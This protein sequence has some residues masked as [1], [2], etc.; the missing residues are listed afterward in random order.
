MKIKIKVWVGCL[1]I[2]IACLLSGCGRE[3]E[4]SVYDNGSWKVEQKL[5]INTNALPNISGD[6][7]GN[8]GLDFNL[9]G[10]TD[11]FIRY[12]FDETISLYKSMDLNASWWADNSN[13]ETTYNLSVNGEDFQSLADWGLG[14]KSKE[15]LNALGPQYQPQVSMLVNTVT[16]E[17]LQDGKYHLSITP[18]SQMKNVPNFGTTITLNA[19][20]IIQSNAIRVNGGTA[21]WRNP[22]LIDVTFIPAPTVNLA[23]AAL[24]GGAALVCGGVI[25]GLYIFGSNR[26]GSGGR[27]ALRSPVRRDLGRRR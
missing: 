12:G 15:L 18:S 9:G 16:L 4:I 24:A 10:M 14:G 1:A 22:T 6:I 13:G 8:I 5:S 21:I 23:T 17:K 19:G 25:F 26:G 7:G 20:E 3:F 11:E 27:V 2:M